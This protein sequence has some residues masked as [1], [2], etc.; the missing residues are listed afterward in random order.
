MLVLLRQPEMEQ[1]GKQDE[2]LRDL[3]FNHLLVRPE[4][5]R[6]REMA[7]LQAKVSSTNGRNSRGA[8]T[9]SDLSTFRG[10]TREDKLCR[11]FTSVRYV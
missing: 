6:V 10:R 2:G 8:V 9:I 1:K 11:R 5:E 4:L 7:W 3:V